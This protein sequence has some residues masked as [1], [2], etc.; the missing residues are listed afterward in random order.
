MEADLIAIPCNTAHAFVDRMQMHLR[1]PVLNMLDEAM[2][3]IAD[4]YAG[5]SACWPRRVRSKA[6][7]TRLRRRVPAFD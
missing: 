4:R 5:R 2:A 3:Q 6:A 1:V 7:S